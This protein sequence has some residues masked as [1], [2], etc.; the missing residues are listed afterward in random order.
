[1]D[2]G[3]YE[4]WVKRSF[5]WAR[6]TER[7]LGLPHHVQLLGIVDAEIRGL[8]QEHFYGDGACPIEDEYGILVLERAQIRAHLWLLGAYE[9]VRMIAQRIDEDPSLATE[10]AI[11]RI[12]EIKLLFARLRMPLA[13][14][15]PAGRHADTDYSI[16]LPGVGSKG[17]GWKVNDSL[18][19]YQEELSDAFLAMLSAIHPR[20]GSDNAG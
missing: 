1:M 15:E 2:L 12:K 16:A 6:D 18:I 4:E 11:A 3:R 5:R 8:R 7:D 19:I 17:L 9:Y 10:A 13:K 14:L 20:S